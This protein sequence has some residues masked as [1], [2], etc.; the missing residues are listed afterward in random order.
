M[1]NQNI[2]IDSKN[3]SAQ[4]WD[5]VCQRV[6]CALTPISCDVTFDGTWHVMADM[7]GTRL[8]AFQYDFKDSVTVVVTSLF[9]I[10]E[11]S[12]SAR[13]EMPS[14]GRLSIS[15]STYHAAMTDDGRLV[16]F[17]DDQGLLLIAAKR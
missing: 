6:G 12:Q 17:N 16:L 11:S 2:P 14:D 3:D 10:D 4:V 9:G 8:L 5:A 7:L 1:P 15:G 13:Y